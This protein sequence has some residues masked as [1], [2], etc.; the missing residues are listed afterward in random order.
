MFFVFF[1][2]GWF[3]LGFRAERS[4]LRTQ[5]LGVESQVEGV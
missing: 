4:G 2:G 5:G 1:P 3:S